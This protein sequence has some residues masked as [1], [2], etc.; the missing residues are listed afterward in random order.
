M[1]LK[2]SETIKI[3]MKSFVVTNGV[4]DTDTTV[5]G[6]RFI[7]VAPNRFGPGYLRFVSPEGIWTADFNKN[8]QLYNYMHKPLQEVQGGVQ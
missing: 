6:G 8:Q 3:T 2:P 1:R 4:K 7:L 5:G